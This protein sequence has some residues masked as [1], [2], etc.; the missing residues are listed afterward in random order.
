VAKFIGEQAVVIGAGLGGLTA[1]AALAEF[2]SKVIVLER[3]ALPAHVEARAGCPQG[4]HVHALLAG[5]QAALE[6]LFP[7]FENDLAAAGAVR[8]NVG[9][10]VRFEEP[11]HDPFPRRDLGI[12]DYCM[13]RPLLEHV[14]RNHVMRMHNVDLRANCV[15]KD[16]IGTPDRTAVTSV[17]CERGDG[18]SEVLAADLVVDASGRGAPSLEFLQVSGQPVQETSIGVDIRYSTAVFA[19]PPDAPADWKGVLVF[20][21]P[22]IDS[23]SAVLLPMEAGRW[24]L[25]LYGAHGDAPPGDVEGFL[26][27]ARQLRTSTV[28]NAVR[29]AEI[30]GEIARFA[31]PASARRHFERV[32]A[33]PRGL[34]PVADAI[35][36][37]N[38]AFGQGMSVAAQEACI[39]R[40]LLARL[41]AGVNPLARLAPAFLADIEAVI[42]TPWAVANVDFVYPQT[43]GE[44]PADFDGTMKFM[45]ALGRLA[46]REP[47]VHK[48]MTEVRQ[49][50]KP[51]S[52]YHE[53]AFAQRVMAEMPSV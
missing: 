34:L 42:A 19:V 36:C 44:R 2:F 14:A 16:V 7:G 4:R 26:A 27:F 37:F 3:D 9:L 52:V 50:L 49:L 39:L 48:L 31:F 38:P 41:S 20:A 51:L 25:T 11:G 10:D 32:E 47:P 18:T 46:A 28:Y 5:G 12:I 1:A 15:G 45:A 40:Q 35:C 21:D 24:I 8:I 17:R 33:F 43:R 6:S 53:P 22:R 30:Q 29:N 13:S 23:R